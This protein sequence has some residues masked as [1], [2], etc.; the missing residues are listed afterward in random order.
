MMNL[1]VDGQEPELGNGIASK[2]GADLRPPVSL[3]V[4][5]PGHELLAYG[6]LLELSP[7]V[8]IVS[9]GS[10]RDSDARIEASAHL[11]RNDLGIPGSVF[12]RWTDLELYEALFAGR[13]GAFL[14]LRDEL[15]D[16]WCAEGV[17]TVICDAYERKIL[18]HDVV[19]LVASAA[20]ETAEKR[21]LGMELLEL[22]NHIA[23]DEERP[24]APHRLAALNLSDKLL[25]KKIEAARGYQ[26]EVIQHEVEEFLRLR[27]EESFRQE[28]LFRAHRKSIDDLENEP[29]PAWEDHG[30]FLMQQGVYD[31]VI[32]LREHVIPLVEAL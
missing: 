26:S 4:A 1:S 13:F 15:V 25:K 12:G 2:D 7:S 29:R 27:G 19:Q 9:D 21:G 30:E 5:H 28:V 17:Q 20:V 6:W 10:G 16:A 23:A 24:G 31:H 18:M 3:V 11:L 32:R 8:H 22:P 14:T